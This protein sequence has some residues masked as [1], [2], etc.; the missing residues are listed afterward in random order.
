MSASWPTVGGTLSVTEEKKK[1]KEK[2]DCFNAILRL[3][4]QNLGTKIRIEY[5]LV[6]LHR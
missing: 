1:E 3:G 6:H 5:S 2:K 4:Y